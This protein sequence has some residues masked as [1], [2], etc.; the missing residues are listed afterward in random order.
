MGGGRILHFA[1]EHGVIGSEGQETGRGICLTGIHVIDAFGDPLG[2]SRVVHDPE[3]R[4]DRRHARDGT[5]VQ[6][7]GEGQ[8]PCRRQAEARRTG[9]EDAAAAVQGREYVHTVVRAGDVH[10]DLKAVDTG[11]DGI[12]KRRSTV[13]NLEC[14]MRSEEL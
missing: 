10:L 3:I 9:T 4:P 11:V 7:Q 2:L 1:L 12:V 5:G 6:V 13:H 8:L 14:V